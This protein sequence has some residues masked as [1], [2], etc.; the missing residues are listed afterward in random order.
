VDRNGFQ[1]SGRTEQCVGLEPLAERWRSFG[2]S[3]REV[4]GHD[5]AAL[6][7][8]LSGLPHAYGR[9]TVIIAHT[10]KGRGVPRFEDRK[11]SHYIKLSKELHRRTIAEMCAVE[12]LETGQ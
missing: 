1:I 11:K 3:C 9:P 2:W 8:A 12:R 6:R 4:D 5:I 10:V 7:G